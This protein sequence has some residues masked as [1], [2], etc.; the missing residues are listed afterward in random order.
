MRKPSNSQSHELR[1]A[2]VVLVAALCGLLVW[3]PPGRT[4]DGKALEPAKYMLAPPADAIKAVNYGTV[5]VWSKSELRLVDMRTGLVI[6]TIPVQGEIISADVFQNTDRSP[7]LMLLTRVSG[8]LKV[9]LHGSE[10]MNLLGEYVLPD[11]SLD[12][13]VFVAKGG[14]TLVSWD[15]LAKKGATTYEIFGLKG[16]QSILAFGPTAQ[17]FATSNPAYVLALHPGSD[18]ASL[19]DLKNGSIED[20]VYVGGYGVSDASQLAGYAPPSNSSVS[21]DVAVVNG[22]QGVLT[23]LTVQHGTLTRIGKPSKIQVRSSD[24]GNQLKPLVTADRQL[25]TIVVGWTGSKTVA[26]FRKLG[27][28]LVGAGTAELDWPIRSMA[29]IHSSTKDAS[30][31]FAFLSDDGRELQVLPD[32]HELGANVFRVDGGSDIDNTNDQPSI[33]DVASVQKVLAKLGFQVGAI[34]G[35]SGRATKA[36]LRSFQF[37]VGVPVTGEIDHA[38]VVA[39]ARTATEMQRVDIPVNLPPMAAGIRAR[40]YNVYIQF[41]GTIKREAVDALNAALRVGGWKVP[42]DPERIGSAAGLNEVRYGEERDAAA[43]KA[44]AD[45]ISRTSLSSAPVTAKQVSLVRPGVLEV[46][47]SR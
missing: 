15:R 24:F 16:K 32:I 31:A 26:I 42:G 43:A 36:A 6:A 9:R 29:A 12:P 34:D 2:V 8:T 25:D 33:G 20:S 22:E 1:A 3:A 44:L 10:R 30:D 5:A 19:L 47:I 4:E 7:G 41:A 37:S 13:A 28:G 21:D 45:A 46:W 38:T 39:L 35:I 27:G 23:V 14:E 18:G 17:M 40:D 11:G